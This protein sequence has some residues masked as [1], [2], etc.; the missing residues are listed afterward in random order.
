MQFPKK[1]VPSFLEY[2]VFWPFMFLNI[3]VV[4]LLCVKSLQLTNYLLSWEDLVEYANS[5]C[6]FVYWS[7]ENNNGDFLIVQM[8]IPCHT[9]TNL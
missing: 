7:I 2:S 8:L 4:Q 6:S 3:L 5:L 9:P 1:D